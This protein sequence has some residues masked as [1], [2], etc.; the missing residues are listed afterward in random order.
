VTE[1]LRRNEALRRNSVHEYESSS[2]PER[3]RQLIRHLAK[4]ITG[5][6]EKKAR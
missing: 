1:V 3:K 4:F 2:R 6:S 5:R